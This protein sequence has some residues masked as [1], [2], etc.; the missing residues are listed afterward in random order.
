MT[1]IGYARVS[2]QE[3]ATN[4]HSLDTQ[5]QMIHAQYQDIEIVTEC[6]SGSSLT[7]RP[8][9]NQL[10]DRVVAGEVACIV[11]AKLDRLSR[12]V[13]DAVSISK[14]CRVVSISESI[15]SYSPT[16]QVHLQM[17]SMFAEQERSNIVSRVRLGVAN[18]LGTEII[19]DN[20]VRDW[21]LA[22]RKGESIASIAKRFDRCYETV[23]RNCKDIKIDKNERRKKIAELAGQGMHK[24]EI[25]KE[26]GCS[27]QTVY[28][29]LAA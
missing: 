3:Q 29:A 15:D 2:T 20:E 7:G 6:A 1:T 19:T 25:A 16:G 14:L 4:G 18:K 5:A 8:A 9:L 26:I 23:R 11:V 24:K 28:N 21:Q 12:S 13:L 17:M 22:R 27:L 10:I